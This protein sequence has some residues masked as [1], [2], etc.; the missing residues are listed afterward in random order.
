MDK[1]SSDKNDTTK[2]LMARAKSLDEL[3]A[4]IKQHKIVLRG[5]RQPFNAPMLV[6]AIDRYLQDG[7]IGHLTSAGNFRF[8]VVN[9]KK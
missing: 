1:Q 5:S 4:I 9:L 7:N 8:T 2:A 6:L 3:K